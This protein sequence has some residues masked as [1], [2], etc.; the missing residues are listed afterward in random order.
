MSDDVLS[1]L[2][3]D[4]DPFLAATG[5]TCAYQPKRLHSK[6][7]VRPASKAPAA[8][9]GVQLENAA[10]EFGFKGRVRLGSG[11]ENVTV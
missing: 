10:F 11:G 9:T 1:G 5:G 7:S 6:S 3:C 8:T 4:R 2:G